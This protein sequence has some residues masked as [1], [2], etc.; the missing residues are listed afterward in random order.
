MQSWTQAH[1]ASD[2]SAGRSRERPFAGRQADMEQIMLWAVVAWRETQSGA[3][4]DCGV[5]TAA[6]E[7]GAPVVGCVDSGDCTASGGNWGADTRPFVDRDDTLDHILALA[8]SAEQG[9]AAS[10][11]GRSKCDADIQPFMACGRSEALSDMVLFATQ[12]WSSASIMDA[13]DTLSDVVDVVVDTHEANAHMDA[14]A[15]PGAIAGEAGAGG[16]G[17]GWGAWGQGGGRGP[18]GRPRKGPDPQGAWGRNVA[19]P[20]NSCVPLS[21]FGRFRPVRGSSTVSN[22]S[23]YWFVVNTLDFERSS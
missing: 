20:Q 12:A 21:D 10:T 22:G 11:S 4:S 2:E 8:E 13:S 14:G 19:N 9:V 1:Q 6:L 17:W 15:S 5:N 3:E 7:S 16:E 23:V 18:G